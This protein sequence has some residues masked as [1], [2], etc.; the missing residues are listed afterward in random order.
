[1][2]AHVMALTVAFDFTSLRFRI[3]FRVLHT[4]LLQLASFHSA[5]VPRHKHRLYHCCY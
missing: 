3:P 5:S 1:M 4:V 2:Y